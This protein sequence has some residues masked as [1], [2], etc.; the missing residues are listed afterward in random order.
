MED[1]HRAVAA[2]AFGEHERSGNVGIPKEVVHEPAK[3]NRDGHE[4]GHSGKRR[5]PLHYL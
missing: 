5:Q 2:E 3:Q 4:I 1:V